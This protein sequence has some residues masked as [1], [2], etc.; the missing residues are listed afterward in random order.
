MIARS[1]RW[2]ALS[3]LAALAAACLCVLTLGAAPTASADPGMITADLKEPMHDVP[4]TGMSGLLS[5]SSSVLPLQ[6]PWLAPGDSFSWQIGLHLRDQPVAGAA[7]EFIPDGGLIHPGTGYRLTAQHCQTQWV[8]RSGVNSQLNC[9]SG[10][11]TLFAESIL[12]MDPA[13]VITLRDLS[14]HESPHILFT[15]SLPENAA[16][17]GSFTFALGF[18]A[19]G[20]TKTSAD[21]MPFT[22]LMAGLLPIACALLASGLIAR[23]APWKGVKP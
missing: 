12:Q 13:T 23:F 17:S 15:L 16:S 5:L 19:M 8:G 1:R 21:E 4:E 6:V 10:T 22:G 20:D 2:L 3:G 7:L 18:T 14:A 11:S 9:P